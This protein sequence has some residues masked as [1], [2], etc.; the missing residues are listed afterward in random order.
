MSV[1]SFRSSLRE[2]I[3]RLGQFA[4]LMLTLNELRHL[5]A[6]EAWLDRGDYCNCFEELKRIAD[7]NDVRVQGLRWRL[8]HAAGLRAAAEEVAL[9]IQRHHPKEIAGHLWRSLSL[10][11]G[12]IPFFLA[13]FAW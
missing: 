10:Q 5:E 13:L 7:G 2:P 6:A 9:D 8:Y 1:A 4:D 11:N 3:C 12:L